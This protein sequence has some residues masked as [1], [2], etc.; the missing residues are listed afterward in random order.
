MENQALDVTGEDKACYTL[1]KSYS[2]LCADHKFGSK[3]S[4]SP[5]IQLV[6]SNTSNAASQVAHW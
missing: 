1:N 6:L 4:G 5:C 3:R 2:L